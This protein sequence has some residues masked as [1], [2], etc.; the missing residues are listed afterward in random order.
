MGLGYALAGAVG[1][2]G[3]GLVNLG[4]Q[5]KKEA[6][7]LRQEQRADKMRAED[8]TYR[9][10]YRQEGWNRDDAV[11]AGNREYDENRKKS[12]RERIDG[13]ISGAASALTGGKANFVDTFMPLAESAAAE[14]GIDPRIIVAQAALES[15]W[16]KSAPNNNY[17]GIKSHGRGLGANLATNEV[18]DGKTVRVNDSFRTYQS[19]EESIKGYVQFLKEN[20]RYREMLQA[21]G[22]EAQ[23]AALGRSGYATDPKYAQKITS[24]VEQMGTT[25]SN[26]DLLMVAG[27]PEVPAS[28]R[29]VAAGQVRGLGQEADRKTAKGADGYLRYVD[30]GER[31]FPDAKKSPSDEYGKYASEEIGAG[32]KPL[33]RI[34]YAQAKKGNGFSVTT[35]DGT[36]VQM[37]GKSEKFTEGQSKDNVFATRAEGALQVFDPISDVLVSRANRAADFDPT[38][39]AREL[40]NPDFQVAKQAGDEFLQAILRKDTGAAITEGEQVLYGKTYIPQP[41]DQPATLAAKRASRKRA[42]EAIKSGMSPAQIIAQERALANSSPKSDD[43]SKS[44]GGEQPPNP[45]AVQPTLDRTYNIPRMTIADFDALT[46]EEL[47][48]LTPVQEDQ[49][50]SQYLRLQQEMESR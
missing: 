41:G 21:D 35:S 24:I 42:L 9:E 31:V 33:S 50:K 40:Q 8:R 1:G 28:L 19:P 39:V 45:S 30:T 25:T 23:I 7:R 16:G 3:A 47:Q 43:Q 12:E 34:E 10:Q 5:K 11:R 22:L 49:M 48:N 13:K 27:D 15:G 2:L 6:E 32:R 20:P 36:T 4:E 26:R 18:I 38:G 44:E 17:F 14:L 37:G 29:G 46:D